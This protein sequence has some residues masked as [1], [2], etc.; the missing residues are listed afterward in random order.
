MPAAVDSIVQPSPNVQMRDT[1][2][3][4]YKGKRTAIPEQRKLDSSRRER[5]REV[6]ASEEEFVQRAVA[7]HKKIRRPLT[8]KQHRFAEIFAYEDVTATEA[9]IKAGYPKAGAACQA[10]RMLSIDQ[11]PHIVA[12]IRKMRDTRARKYQ[13][14]FENHVEMLAKIRDKALDADSFSAAIN[15]EKARGQVAGL[16]VE[17]KEVLYGNIDQMDK[18]QVIKEIKK[19]QKEF[20]QLIQSTNPAHIEDVEYEEVDINEE[21]G[22]QTLE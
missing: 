5:L 8:A 2:R 21:S 20:P 3:G 22:E 9:A 13:V 11:S 7:V 14:T 15:A 10:S 17:R 6:D 19:L 18:D 12:E 1:T 4:A 16:Y